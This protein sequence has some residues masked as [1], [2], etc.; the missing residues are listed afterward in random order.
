MRIFFFGSLIIIFISGSTAVFSDSMRFGEFLCTQPQYQCRE[1]EKEESWASIWEEPE[2]QNQI[3]RLNRMNIKLKPGMKI[4]V[5]LDKNFFEDSNNFPFPSKIG[6]S[7]EKQIQVDLSIL[8]WAAYDEE[9][10]LL[11]WGPASGGK[12]WCPDI[13][14]KCRTPSGKFYLIEKGGVSCKSHK[15]PIPKGG[16]PMP[17]CMFFKKGYALHGSPEVP[18]YHASH[19]CVRL[20]KEDAQWLNEQFTKNQNPEKEP[21]PIKIIIHP[22]SDLVSDKNHPFH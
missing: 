3:K 7:G 9:G 5:P 21:G 19:G 11:K 10:H 20:F 2:K 6:T 1:I 15:F 12:A 18:G 16:A 8:A 17:Y 22:Y 13:H 4:A 14:A